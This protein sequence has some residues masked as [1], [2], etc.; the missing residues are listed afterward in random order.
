MVRKTL[1]MHD[2]LI[3]L[4]VENTQAAANDQATPLNRLG[5]QTCDDS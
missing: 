5:D 4:S 3:S 2:T 1:N